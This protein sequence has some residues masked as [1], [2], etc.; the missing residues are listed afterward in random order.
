MYGSAFSFA[1]FLFFSLIYHLF[2]LTAKLYEGREDH[3]LFLSFSMHSM[4]SWHSTDLPFYM[5]Y[6][7]NL[8]GF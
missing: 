4:S 2:F 7:K 8:G 3:F 1:L 6:H 5:V